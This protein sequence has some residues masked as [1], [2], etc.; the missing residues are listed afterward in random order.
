MTITVE[1]V[2]LERYLTMPIRDLL[3]DM[4]LAVVAY[5]DVMPRFVKDISGAQAMVINNYDLILRRR[6]L[7][8]KPLPDG[9]FAEAQEDTV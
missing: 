3:E 8:V 9:Q 5:C 6:G 4:Y 7:S 2:I 1:T